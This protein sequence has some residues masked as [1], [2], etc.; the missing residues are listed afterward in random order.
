MLARIQLTPAA[1]SDERR[2]VPHPEWRC[3]FVAEAGVSVALPLSR[4]DSTKR[5]SRSRRRVRPPAHVRDPVASS[6][7]TVPGVHRPGVGSGPLQLVTKPLDRSTWPDFAQLA[8]DHHGA[9]NGCWCLNFHAEGSPNVHSPEER[10]R[11][12]QERVREGRAH[13]AVVCDD[14][15]C[16]GWCQY[17]P[18]NELPRIKHQKVYRAGLRDLPDWRITCFFVGRIHRRRGVADVALAG[19]LRQIAQ[20]GGGIIESYP[21]DT[22]GRKTSP[23]FLYNGTVAMFERHGFERDRQIGKDHWVVHRSIGRA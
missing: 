7:A 13:A 12:K 3:F 4:S 22:T 5:T 6:V 18:A 17:G 8:E 9:W 10:R 16:V 20:S 21:E 15:H 23:W 2:S 1:P 14:A 11:L 19:A